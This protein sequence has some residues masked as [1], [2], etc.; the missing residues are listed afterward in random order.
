M[1]L[2]LR[3]FRSDCFVTELSYLLRTQLA[4]LTA[5]HA[6]ISFL[7]DEVQRQSPGNYRPND[8]GATLHSKT[9]KFNGMTPKSNAGRFLRQNAAIIFPL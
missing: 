6:T 3:V 5:W 8:R 1:A 7:A 2:D 9:H 4:Y